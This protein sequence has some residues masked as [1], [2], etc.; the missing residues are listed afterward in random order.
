MPPSD[1]P[2]TDA[3]APATSGSGPRRTVQSTPR[4]PYLTHA[5]DTL[6]LAAPISMGHLSYLAMMTATLMLFGTLAPDAL[7]AGGLSLRMGLSTH[8]VAGILLC[9]GVLVAEA[10]G[11]R[12]TDRIPGFYWN[13]LYLS[14]L[15]SVVSFTWFSLGHHVLIAL[16]QPPAVVAQTRDC[17]EIMRWAEPANLIRLGLMRSVL[18]AFGLARVL[19]LL[20]PLSLLVYAGLAWALVG[21]EFGLPALGWHGIPTAMVIAMTLSALAMLA[22]VHCTRFRR[23]IPLARPS[24]ATLGEILRPGLPIGAQ[25][26]VDGLFFLAM[27]L[28]VGQLGAVALAAHQI[29]H[30]FGTICYVLAASCGDAA[31]LR[32]S[33][34]RGAKAFDDAAT[35]GYVAFVLGMAGMAVAATIIYVTP[36]SFIGLFIDVRAPENAEILAFAL[37]LIPLCAI[38]VL[39]DGFYGVGMGL[40]RGLADNTFTLGLVTVSYWGL[41]FPIG[42]GLMVWADLGAP[43]LWWGLIAGLTGIG[44]GA[45]WR[46]SWLSREAAAGRM[47]PPRRRLRP[48]VVTPAPVGIDHA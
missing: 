23:Q 37:S 28:L 21:G 16:D 6:R 13:G 33:F 39:A 44:A 26:T 40:Q 25:M 5:A 3:F 12:E 24:L 15:L 7:A 34:R 20:T 4:E 31:A 35:A 14:G 32:I 30:N 38:Y 17:L 1:I 11:A 41:G 27:T 36:E 10:Q 19:Y 47:P 18:P 2:A 9:V 45:I 43:A 22:T 8:V 46:Y 48:A 42:Y 29:V